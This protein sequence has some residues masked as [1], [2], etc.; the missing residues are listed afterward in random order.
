MALLVA[1]P[2]CSLFVWLSCSIHL[3]HQVGVQGDVGNVKVLL[4]NVITENLVDWYILVGVPAYSKFIILFPSFSNMLSPISL[5]PIL[6]YL[7]G[8]LLSFV[9]VRIGSSCAFLICCLAEAIIILVVASVRRIQILVEQPKSSVM[10]D[11]QCWQHLLNVLGLRVVE[12]FM[13]CYGHFMEK[14]TFLLGNMPNLQWQLAR[15]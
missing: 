10:F 4:S 9:H 6:L 1:G 3:R 7:C 14:P 8:H 11:M 13:G 2:P 12:T 15:S 5:S